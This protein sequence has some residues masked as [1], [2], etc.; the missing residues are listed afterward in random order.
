MGIFFCFVVFVSSACCVSGTVIADVDAS[1][2]AESIF[3]PSR[4]TKPYYKASVIDG[5][6]VFADGPIVIDNAHEDM[7]FVISSGNYPDYSLTISDSDSSDQKLLQ[8]EL[9]SADT[10][11]P[12]FDVISLEALDEDLAPISRTTVLLFNPSIQSN[13]YKMI[14][15]VDGHEYIILDFFYFKWFL[16]LLIVTGLLILLIELHEIVKHIRISR[17]TGNYEQLQTV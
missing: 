1:A 12:D 4:F 10:I 3:R 14:F 17:K 7:Y 8:L 11:I 15:K 16:G 6:I 9:I 13:I 5:Q 2:L